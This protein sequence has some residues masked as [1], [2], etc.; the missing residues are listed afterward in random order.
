M[1]G[2]ETTLG[3]VATKLI[4]PGHLDWLHALAKLST[5]PAAILNLSGKGTLAV[6]ADA[7]VVVIDP[8]AKWVVDAK[9]FSSRSRNTPLNGWTLD[10]RPTDVIVGGQIKRRDSNRA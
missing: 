9:A 7:D 3:L 4:Q 1:V 2:V 8:L 6:G 5:N 10:A